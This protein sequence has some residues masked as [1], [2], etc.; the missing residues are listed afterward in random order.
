MCHAK[1]LIVVVLVSYGP[2]LEQFTDTFLDRIE[3][4]I[5]KAIVINEITIHYSYD[6]MTQLAYG[7]AGGF[8]SGAS[9]KAANE[10]LAGIQKGIDAIGLLC[11]V[12]W[13][14]TLLTTFAGLGGPM[15]VFN[16]WSNDAL[17]RR[18]KEGSKDPDLMGY[19][20]DATKP[21]RKGNNLLFSESRAIIGAGSDTTA[22]ALTE[23]FILLA[24]FPSYVRKIREEMDPI[25]VSGAFS[26][27][28]AYPVLESVIMETLRLHPPVLFGSQRVTPLEGLHIGEIYIPG[29]MVVYIPQWQIQHDAR[30]FTR[31]DDF[32]PERWSSQPQL[33]KNRSAY[34]PFNIG[35]GNCPGRPLAM[36]E[37]RSVIARTLQ[38]Y[39]VSFPKGYEFDISF[40][41]DVKDHFVAAVPKME[42]VFSKRKE[43]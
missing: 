42:L 12:P 40:F 28:T 19:L 13:I 39:D 41:K 21:D 38:K 30:N 36:M 4:D 11:Q 10:V 14:M 33:I 34:I 9:T 24:H 3:V 7:K 15:K 23:L 20:I 2:R 25:F 32:I 27:Q 31:P 6:V 8:L 5:G 1:K 43:A 29:D 16:D 26:C 22:T 35:P 17:V 18:K 37:L